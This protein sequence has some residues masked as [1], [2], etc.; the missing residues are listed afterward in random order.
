MSLGRGGISL[1]LPHLLCSSTISAQAPSTLPG[2]LGLCCSQLSTL[3]LSA[4]SQP[5]IRPFQVCRTRFVICCWAWGA[6]AGV[7]QSRQRGG[8]SFFF[9]FFLK[10]AYSIHSSNPPSHISLLPLQ[11]TSRLQISSLTSGLM[12][13]LSPELPDPRGHSCPLGNKP[14]RR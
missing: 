5:L 12:S 13:S 9:L 3:F 14:R 1:G 2:P 10:C 11:T 4:L 8:N 6:G 7:W